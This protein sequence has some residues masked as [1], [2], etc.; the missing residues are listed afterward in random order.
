VLGWI[1][2]YESAFLHCA[3]SLLWL[4]QHGA[5]IKAYK[6]D[7]WR[8]SALHYAACSGDELSCEVLL[9]YGADAAARNFAGR[10]VS[11]SSYGIIVSQYSDPSIT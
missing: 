10:P 1:S 6:A 9:A 11:A 7:G 4:L 2:A 8:D 3:V 5:D